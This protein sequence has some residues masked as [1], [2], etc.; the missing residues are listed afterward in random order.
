MLKYLHLLFSSIYKHH[1]QISKGHEA[2]HPTYDSPCDQGNVGCFLA[3]CG[4]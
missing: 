4:N 1:S 3:Y 2:S